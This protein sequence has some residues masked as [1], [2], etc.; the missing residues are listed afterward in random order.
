MATLRVRIDGR[1]G[2]ISADSFATVIQRSL[3]ILHDLDRRLTEERG[4]TL[5]WVIQDIGGSSAWVDLGARVIRGP[6]D[7]SV[8]VHRSFTSGLN[9]ISSAQGSPPYFSLRNVAAVRKIVREIASDGVSG[10]FYEPPPEEVPETPT[11]SAISARLTS[12]TELELQR[13]TGVHYRA[14][15]S[16][17]GRVELVSVRKRSR[18]FNITHERTLRPI[19]CNLPEALEDSAF[20]AIR[21]RRRVV[22]TGL[23]SYNARHEPISLFTDKPLRFLGKEEELPS[24]VD[25]AA[26]DLEITGSLATEDFVRSLR[27]DQ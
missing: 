24:A 18:R 4:G 17:E 11:V 12:A 6:Q 5:K 1:L 9:Q 21:Q 7:T 19:R 27:D 10:V 15:G 3:E 26:S 13:L 8:S 22:A 20:D 14:L 23:I 2:A 16:I 25:L